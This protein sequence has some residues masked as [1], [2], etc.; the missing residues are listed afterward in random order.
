MCFNGVCQLS[1]QFSCLFS[2]KHNKI[3]PADHGLFSEELFW[4]IIR[5]KVKSEI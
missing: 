2:L 3:S 4:G 1:D 5:E